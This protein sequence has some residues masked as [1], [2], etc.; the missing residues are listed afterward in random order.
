MSGMTIGS[1]IEADKRLREHEVVVR[2]QKVMRRD[3]EVWRR[4]E[5][6]YVDKETSQRASDG[7]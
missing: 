5:A 2:R 4:Y 3:A 7:K 1:M 6:D